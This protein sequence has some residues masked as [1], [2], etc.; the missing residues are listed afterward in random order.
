MK[1]YKSECG[2]LNVSLPEGLDESTVGKLLTQSIDNNPNILTNIKQGS[3]F[4]IGII[5][6]AAVTKTVTSDGYNKIK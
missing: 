3:N 4:S 6:T 2:R 1:I 5:P